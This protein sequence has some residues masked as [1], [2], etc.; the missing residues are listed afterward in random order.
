M[1][2]TY[3]QTINSEVKFK[4]ISLH[5]GKISNVK[6]LPAEENNG[7]IFKRVDLREKKYY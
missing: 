1:L 5:S 7:I 6:L 2:K 3:Q 4:G